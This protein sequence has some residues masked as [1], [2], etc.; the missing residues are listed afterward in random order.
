[1]VHLNATLEELRDVLFFFNDSFSTRY[2]SDELRSDEYYEEGSQLAK[3]ATIKELFATHLCMLWACVKERNGVFKSRHL[4]VNDKHKL[5]D[6]VK[7]VKSLVNFTPFLEQLVNELKDACKQENVQPYTVNQLKL[8]FNHF[9]EAQNDIHT[10]SRK[11][12]DLQTLYRVM[13]TASMNRAHIYEPANELIVEDEDTLLLESSVK[14]ADQ[15]AIDRQRAEPYKNIAEAKNL[16]KNMRGEDDEDKNLQAPDVEQS[17]DEH[18]NLGDDDDEFRHIQQRLH[19]VPAKGWSVDFDSDNVKIFR[20]EM[21]HDG[22][23]GEFVTRCTAKVPKFPKHVIFKALSD[24]KLRAKW[25]QSATN[26]QVV[27]TDTDKGQVIVK[28]N[29]NV[30]SHMQAR[31]VVVATKTKKDFPKVGAWTI[32]QTSVSNDKCPEVP[33]NAARAEV[34]INGIVLEDAPEVKGT[35]ITWVCHQDYHGP[36]TKTMLNN[37][38]VYQHRLVLEQLTKACQLIIKGSLK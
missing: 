8:I 22:N 4:S 30:P 32:A 19:D 23:W 18:D 20:K 13:H 9:E 31:E 27:E 36:I 6:I 11:L 15:A 1:M 2:L 16:L 21:N 10:E 17:F 24:M 37:R 35:K 34:R 38:A 29:I 14:K 5:N 3:L 26:F 33:Q 12:K 7:K 28:Y 25:D